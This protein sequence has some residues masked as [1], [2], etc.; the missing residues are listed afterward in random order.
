MTSP[1]ATTRVAVADASARRRTRGSSAAK[2]ISAKKNASSRRAVAP[3]AAPAAESATTSIDW[4]KLDAEFQ[5]ATTIA[6]LD[7]ALEIF[8][9]TLAIAFSGAEDVALIQYASLTG[10]PFRVFS[11]D[12]GRLNPETYQLFDDVEKHFGIKIEFTFPDEDAVV[13]LVNEKGMFSFYEDGH[14]ARLHFPASLAFNPRTRCLSTPPLT[15]LS[16]PF[17]GHKECCGVRKVQPLRKKLKT[18]NAWVTG[19]RKDQS[20]GTRMAVPAVQIDPVFEGASGGAG[21]LVKF[22]PLTNATSQ[23]AFFSHW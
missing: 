3:A 15:C 12:T 13:E 20:P 2:K 11:L 23:G 5:D 1:L 10:R 8:G 16:T 19:Q 7:R 4:E 22:N 18:L 14:K 6:I 17:N 9:D 21:S